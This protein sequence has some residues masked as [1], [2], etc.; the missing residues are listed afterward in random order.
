MQFVVAGFEF[1]FNLPLN[2]LDLSFQ[3][4]NLVLVLAFREALPTAVRLLSLKLFSRPLQL[5]RLV[6]HRQLHPLHLLL[7]L[8]LQPHQLL[9]LQQQRI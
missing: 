2:L 8:V 4:H 5:L 1:R 9:L 3:R 6:L 7:D